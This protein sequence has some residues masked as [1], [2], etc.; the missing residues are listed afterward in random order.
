MLSNLGHPSLAQLLEDLKGV[1]DDDA[2]TSK[3]AFINRTQ[4]WCG[5]CACMHAA[6]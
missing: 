5:A 1:L 6:R 3:H 4:Q 2:H